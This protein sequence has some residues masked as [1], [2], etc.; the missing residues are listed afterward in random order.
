MIGV[1]FSQSAN[2]VIGVGG[3]IPWRFPGDLR[4]FKR[5]TVGGVVIMGRRTLESIGRALPGRVNVVVASRDLTVPE[6]AYVRSVEQAIDYAEPLRKPVWLI[7]GTR[8]YEAALPHADVVDRTW[9]PVSVDLPP[10]VNCGHGYREHIPGSRLCLDGCGCER[11][12]ADVAFA[13]EVDPR[14]FATQGLVQHEDE[15]ELKR[16]VLLR[17]GA[18]EPD[19]DFANRELQQLGCL[20]RRRTC[21]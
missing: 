12:D 11:Y 8:V 21:A 9:V 14:T 2:G 19:Q 18:E 1:I 16:E 15:P 20:T 6:V 7:G 3:R 13:P 5:M 17:D 4:R 10:C